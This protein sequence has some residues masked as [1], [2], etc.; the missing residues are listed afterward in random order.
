MPPKAVSGFGIVITRLASMI[1]MV[2]VNW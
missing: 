2:G 1:A